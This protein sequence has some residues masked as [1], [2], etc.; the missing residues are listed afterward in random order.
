MR[1]RTVLAG[2]AASSVATRSRAQG[3]TKASVRLKWLAQTQFAGFYLAK[4]RG[5]YEAEGID[6]TITRAARTC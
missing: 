4:A 3:L 2:L 1:R 5:Y 6:L